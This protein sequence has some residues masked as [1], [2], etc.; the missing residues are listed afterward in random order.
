MLTW[1][2]DWNIPHMGPRHSCHP[3]PFWPNDQM[4]WQ[5]IDKMNKKNINNCISQLCGSKGKYNPD[6]IHYY[7]LFLL[8][9]VHLPSDVKKIKGLPKGLWIQA[10]VPAVPKVESRPAHTHGLLELV[11]CLSLEG[12]KMWDVVPAFKGLPAS[13]GRKTK[14]TSMITIP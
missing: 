12:R 5:I 10:P 8:C 2:P 3:G 1:A 9:S 13:L 4:I 14:A 7:P 6:W 11:P